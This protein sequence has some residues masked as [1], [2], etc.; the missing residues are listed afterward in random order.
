MKYEVR[1]YI[2]SDNGV[3]VTSYGLDEQLP[4]SPDGYGVYER[5]GAEIRWITDFNTLERALED[6]E[7]RRGERP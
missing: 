7:R 3:Y 5:R 2:V 6:V 4:K 1:P